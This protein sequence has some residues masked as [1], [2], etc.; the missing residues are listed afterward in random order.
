[1][2][3]R[4]ESPAPAD[5]LV[6]KHTLTDP[7]D[8]VGKEQD[9]EEALAILLKALSHSGIQLNATST[10]P[11]GVAGAQKIITRT[12]CLGLI[13]GQAGQAGQACTSVSTTLHELAPVLRLDVA[14]LGGKGGCKLADLLDGTFYPRLADR[15]EESPSCEGCKTKG[16]KQRLTDRLVPPLTS[17]S[18]SIPRVQPGP[19]LNKPEEGQTKNNA[20]L[21]VPLTL[22]FA[23]YSATAAEQGEAGLPGAAVGTVATLVLEAA[24]IHLGDTPERGHLVAL[25]LHSGG[26][27]YYCNDNNITLPPWLQTQKLLQQ[28]HLLS[29]APPEDA[30]KRAAAS[31]AKRR[32]SRAARPPPV[33]L[34]GARRLLFL[35]CPRPV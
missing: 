33:V 4:G 26:G 20:P 23:P 13:S 7:A 9:P 29:Y 35:S 28:A 25:V 19:D 12:Q 1:M 32:E 10:T 6:L 16:G 15:A 11:G 27:Y 30:M 8:I 17:V 2:L 24:I 18:L 14:P 5:L 21:N 31:E 3:E 22:D 34:G